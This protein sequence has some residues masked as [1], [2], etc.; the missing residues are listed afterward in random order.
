MDSSDSFKESVPSGGGGGGRVL[1]LY[2]LNG[3]VPLDTG[4]LFILSLLNRVC[5]IA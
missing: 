5:N 1:P 3:D 4:I 2:G